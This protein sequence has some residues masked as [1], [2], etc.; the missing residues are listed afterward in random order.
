[1]TR[2]WA[3]FSAPPTNLDWVSF[4]LRS[5]FTASAF[6]SEMRVC[7]GRKILGGYVSSVISEVVGSSCSRESLSAGEGDRGSAS[8]AEPQKR[9]PR[10]GGSLSSLELPSLGKARKEG[11][12]RRS[13]YSYR[14]WEVA[15]MTGVQWNKSRKTLQSGTGL[16]SSG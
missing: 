7:L 12:G 11:G 9:G 5:F 13:Q 15:G 6:S 2:G 14:C 10:L 1:M 3:V 4:F 16:K 8:G